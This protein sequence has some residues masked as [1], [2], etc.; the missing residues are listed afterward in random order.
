MDFH[1]QPQSGLYVVLASPMRF[2]VR[3]S[4]ED[5][6]S[7]GLFRPIVQYSQGRF[8]RW[9]QPRTTTRAE[10]CLEVACAG[11]PSMAAV[12]SVRPWTADP[13]RIDG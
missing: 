5:A 9:R 6:L 13:P 1:G 4:Q 3:C 8:G 12:E 2:M 7:G 10:G 11:N